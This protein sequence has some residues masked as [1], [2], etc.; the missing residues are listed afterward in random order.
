MS[1]PA[2]RHALA[3][4][5]RAAHALAVPGRA[6]AVFE[7]SFYVATPTGLACLGDIGGGPLNVVLDGAP[8]RLAIG[9]SV[10]REG[11]MLKVGRAFLV[12]LASAET[13]RPPPMPPWHA[14]RIRNGLAAIAALDVPREGLAPLLASLAGA[15]RSGPLSDDLLLARARPALARL[16]SWARAPNDDVSFLAPLAGLGPGLTPSGDDAVG[17]AMIAARAFGFVADADAIAAAVAGW[18]AHATSAISRAHLGAAAGG[19]GMAAFH[20]TLAAVGAGDGV[21]AA[22]ACRALGAIGHSSGWDALAGAVGILT[23]LAERPAAA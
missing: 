8:P 11:P 12:A 23:G 17:G 4:G 7:R 13:W 10:L 16:S 20:E 5:Q 15:P 19:E 21:R 1:A 2:T 22:A 18:P 9:D 6:L 14:P 3:W